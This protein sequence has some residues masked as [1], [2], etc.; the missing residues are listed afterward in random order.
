MR[1]AGMEYDNVRIVCI[2]VLGC[3]KTEYSASIRSLILLTGALMLSQSPAGEIVVAFNPFSL[4]QASTV[5]V[6]SG[7]GDT[8]DTTW[9]H[10]HAVM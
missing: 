6:L 4:S 7:L 10:Q 9:K 8:K 2:P 3:V 1:S 5:A